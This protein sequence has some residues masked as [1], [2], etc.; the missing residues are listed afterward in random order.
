MSTN[1]TRRRPNR[2]YNALS[3]PSSAPPL[4]L[5][6]VV[7]NFGSAS[8][9][10]LTVAGAAVVPANAAGGLRAVWLQGDGSYAEVPAVSVTDAGPDGGGNQSIEIQW[11]ANIPGS[12]VSLL[13]EWGKPTVQ[14]FAGGQLG[15]LLWDGQ[16]SG[17]LAF[18]GSVV[19][20][21]YVTNWGAGG[22]PEELVFDLNEDCV[23][24]SG[25]DVSSVSIVASDAGALV[26]AVPVSGLLI[27][28]T[29]LSLTFPNPVN[30]WN[31]YTLRVG[32]LSTIVRG[33]TSG[34]FLRALPNGAVWT[35]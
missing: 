25:F 35:A 26:T 2:R 6:A 14:S 4:P 3:R 19:A 11:A 8:L 16:I 1:G 24:P 34:L 21:P 27:G 7:W 29:Q 18:P 28:P 10:R 9:S 31:L 23:E 20:A 30:T 13:W 15:A 5:L 22:A 17:S 32:D 12:G 33:L